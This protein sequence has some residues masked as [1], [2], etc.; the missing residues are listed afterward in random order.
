MKFFRK[1]NAQ[2]DKTRPQT[3]KPNPEQSFYTPHPGEAP[4]DEYSTGPIGHQTH[5]TS[6][7]SPVHIRENSNRASN[8]AIAVLLLRAV[9]IVVLLVGGLIALKLVLD[10]MA[11]PSEKK[12]QEWAANAG[13]MEKPSAPGAVSAGAPVPQELMISTALI[14]QRLEQW[15]QTEQLLRSAEALTRR[16]INEEASQQLEQTLRISPNNREAQQMLID[17]YMQ[18]GLYAEATPLCIRLLD[19]DSRSPDLQMK[20]LQALHASGQVDAGLVLADR[21]LQD[22]PNNQTV[23]SIAAEGQIKQGGKAAALAL[24]ER[25][26]ANDPKNTGALGGCAKLYLEQGGYQKAVSYYLEL[27]RLDPKPEHYQALARC[28]AQQN[29]A[30][31]AVVFMGQ[32]ASLFG[33]AAVSSWLRDTVFDPVRETVE[34]RS[35]ADR[36][37]GIETRKAI[38]AINKREAEKTTPAVLGGGL[39]LPK[40]PDLNAIQPGK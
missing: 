14:G 28:Y 32:A 31:K 5:R 38:E 27:V 22:Q 37:V 2:P 19:Q 8:W 39:E 15:K 12:Q 29:D 9:L 13:R 18:Q 1:K 10:R 17:V 25:M 24:F 26:L 16:G 33:T 34:F 40:Q 20:L 3:A 36:I 7:H 11:E 21:M 6:R 23:L 4:L 30:G 35:F